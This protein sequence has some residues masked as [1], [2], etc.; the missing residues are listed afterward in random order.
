MKPGFIPPGLKNVMWFGL[1]LLPGVILGWVGTYIPR[2]YMARRLPLPEIA[3]YVIAMKFLLFLSVV[4]VAFRAAF[5]P[6]S[7]K[8][9]YEQEDAS[10]SWYS[11]SFNLYAAVLLLM[12]TA[13]SAAAKPL[14]TVL[15]PASY[16]KAAELVPLLTIGSCVSLAATSLN[17][18]NQVAK[19]TW[20]WSV[21][22]LMGVVVMILA[23]V[24]LLPVL[25]ILAAA[26]AFVASAIAQALVVYLT[27]Q[28][29]FKVPYENGSL[30]AAVLA[31]LSLI[32]IDWLGSVDRLPHG[33]PESANLTI[34]ML[35]AW[36]ILTPRDR[37]L[38]VSSGRQ[39][40]GAVRAIV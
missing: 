21:A 4:G 1:P 25:G 18:G 28:A 33:L 29:S 8:V 23:L 10:R 36:F 15:A 40:V 35:G 37:V 34:G 24:Y 20:N 2:F 39:L 7:M 6:L 13:I 11:S 19:K 16:A 27:S 17:I 30:Y 26:V 12:G 38:L 9:L 31:T 5:E 32:A 22:T 3:I 14:V